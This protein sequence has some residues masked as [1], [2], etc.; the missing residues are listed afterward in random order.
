M[1]GTAITT[2][3]RERP[4]GRRS[5]RD[6]AVDSLCFVLAVGF[7][8]L[9]G[10]QRL[11][12]APLDPAWLFPLDQV[13]GAVGCLALWW[14][15]RWPLAI[16]IALVSVSWFSEL[17]AGPMLVAIFT[18]AVH[19]PPRIAWMVL[20]F[21]VLT[22]YGYTVLRPETGSPWLIV[23][24]LAVSLQTAAGGWGIMIYHRRKLVLS[25][26]DRAARAEAE[27]DL[28]AEQ[29]QL[30][31]RDAIARE[32]H[33]VLGHRLSLLSVHAGALE[34]RSDATR[35][36]VAGAAKVIRENAH[37][38]LQDLREVIGVLR[39]PV[40]EMPQP[41][42]AD[43]PELVAESVEAGMQVRLA[44]VRRGAGPERAGRVAYRI[45]Q[46]GLTN[47]RKHASGAEVQVTLAGRPGDGLTVEICN[48]AG[49]DEERESDGAGQ[50]LIGL[51]ERVDLVGGR[52]EHGRMT[53]GGWRLAAWLPWPP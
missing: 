12:E 20:G 40:G 34:F 10:T 41:G 5:A 25:L 14:R 8:L 46:E 11:N 51:A 49:G 31:A 43:V 26:R 13:L 29:A 36:E 44:D 16:A 52:L 15:R 50:G 35:E 28:R 22:A 53:D 39:A 19:R 45:V 1:S 23:F 6:W 2:T 7:G 30:R 18:V 38:A 33:D 9:L 32:I 17:T 27:A 4:P 24:L 3:E 21:S 37:Q 48:R 42:L 47:V